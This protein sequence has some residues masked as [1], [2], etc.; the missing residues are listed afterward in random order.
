MSPVSVQVVSV[1]D[2][3]LN[4]V[5]EDTGLTMVSV[6]LVGREEMPCTLNLR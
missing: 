3:M 5:V 2:R 4:G 1:T 6:A